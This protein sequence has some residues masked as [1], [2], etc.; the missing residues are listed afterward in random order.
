MAKNKADKRPAGIA[1][2]QGNNREVG[3]GRPP[4]HTRFRKGQ[5]GNPKGRPRSAV[6]SDTLRKAL[7]AAPPGEQEAGVESYADAI[8]RALIDKALKGDVAAFKEIADRTEGQARR[9]TPPPFRERERI[10]R[11]IRSIKESQ[12][13]WG[14]AVEA[15][16]VYEPKALTL[17]DEY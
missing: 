14:E 4:L 17:L 16:A 1:D 12:C 15:F 3:Y 2:V 9:P 8:A 13:T 10:E 7:A 5:S 6:I 11:A